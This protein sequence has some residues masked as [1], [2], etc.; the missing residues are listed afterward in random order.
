M[1]F[2]LLTQPHM[3]I[4]AVKASV[5][6]HSLNKEYDWYIK[7]NEDGAQ[8][9]GNEQAGFIKD[10]HTCYVG[11]PDE[12]VIYLTFDAGYENGNTASILDTLKKHNAP[13]AFFLVGS[14]FKRNPDLVKRMAAEGHLVCNHSMTHKNM[15]KITDFESYKAEIKKAEE[16][17]L[18]ET[19]CTMAPFFR[20]PEGKFSEQSL[21]YNQ[22]LGY[23]TVF[24]SFAYVDWYNDKQPSEE[25]GMKKIIGRT[26]PGAIVLLHSNSKT[27]TRILD[28]VISKWEEM[29]YSL[30]SLNELVKNNKQGKT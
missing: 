6:S 4:D 27:N 19:G 8:P 18:Q 17:C 5:G 22:D 25:E 24:W 16:V 3:V 10:Y 26:H 15:A 7:P 30:K 20:P 14:Y 9:Q 11:S 29:G 2:F 1:R 28:R 13:A 23:T 12:K 21:K